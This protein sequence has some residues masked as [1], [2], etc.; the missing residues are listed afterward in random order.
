VLKASASHSGSSKNGPLG[1]FCVRSQC[2][3]RVKR[4]GHPYH[5]TEA[6]PTLRLRGSASISRVGSPAV[7]LTI[8]CVFGRTPTKQGRAEGQ[9]LLPPL[10]VGPFLF[11]FLLWLRWRCSAFVGVSVIAHKIENGTERLGFGQPPFSREQIM[12]INT[13]TCGRALDRSGL[14]TSWQKALESG[15][16]KEMVD[17]LKAAEEALPHGFVLTN[18]ITSLLIQAW[19]IFLTF[20]FQFLRGAARFPVP[21]IRLRA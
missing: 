4:H 20:F 19:F 18:T 5:E 10:A 11:L 15:T 14:R 21:R 7:A 9:P 12:Q 3:P 17:G 1:L 2:S 8:F 16:N 13:K 6:T